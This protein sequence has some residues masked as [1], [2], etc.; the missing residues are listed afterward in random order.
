MTARLA[1][2]LHR[3]AMVVA[4]ALWAAPAVGQ[5]PE[6]GPPPADLVRPELPLRITPEDLRMGDLTPGDVEALREYDDRLFA[7]ARSIQDPALRATTL[8]RVARSKIIARRLD[9]A[10]VA[11]QEAGR[12]ALELPPGLLRDLRLMAITSNLVVLAHEQVVEGVPNSAVASGLAGRTPVRS[13]EA[14]DAWLERAMG[15]W[16]WAAELAAQITNPNYR[17]EHLTKIVVGQ[18]DDALKVGR[19]AGSSQTLRTDLAGEA[20]ELLD[21]ADRVLRQATEQA[22]RIDRAVWSDR[23]LYEVAVSAGRAG[24]YPRALQIAREIPRPTPRAEALIRIAEAMARESAFL[25]DEMH[26]GLRRSA[27]NLRASLDA[28]RRGPAEA[29]VNLPPALSDLGLGLSGPADEVPQRLE[30]LAQL[31]ENLRRRALELTILFQSDARARPGIVVLPDG[32]AAQARRTEEL[33][34]RADELGDAVADLRVQIVPELDKAQALDEPERSAALLR[35]IP[36]ADDPRLK[37]LF[38]RIEA[39][40]AALLAMADPMVAGATEAYHESARSVAAVA[41]P[42]LRAVTARLLTQSLINVG[43]FDDARAAT[44]LLPDSGHRYAIWGAIAESQGRR[45]LADSAMRWIDAEA[46]PEIRPRLYRR[47]EEGILAT[48]DQI[49]SQTNSMIG[50]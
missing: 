12:A 33:A 10:H 47:L 28:A 6:T 48:V 38:E 31:A 42:D 17:C 22:E 27:D 46:P 9:D 20:P 39:A 4:A 37:A 50:R 49:R 11:L 14:R 43:R 8:N 7:V 32:P 1:T 13:T 40:D 18:A 15:E 25:R 16:R 44:G 34:T 24:L 29:D 2:G 21:Y 3:G 5:I 35:A 19:D 36:A 41:L 26:Q 45:G 23:A 30:G